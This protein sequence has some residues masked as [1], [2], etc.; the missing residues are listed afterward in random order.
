MSADHE[1]RKGSGGDQISVRPIWPKDVDRINLRC[2]PDDEEAR[3]RLFAQ[4]GT[5]GMAAWEGDRC[6]GQLHCYRVDLPDWESRD[7]PGRTADDLKMWPLGWPLL[8]AREARLTFGGSVWGHSCFH[9]GLT[10]GRSDADSSYHNRGIGT[11]MC[12]ASVDW[13][14]R[15]GYSAV[16]AMGGPAD[17][18]EYLDWMGV[19]PWTTYARMGFKTATLEQ[20]GKKLPWWAQGGASPKVVEQV[21]AALGHGRPIQDLCARSMVLD[22]T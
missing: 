13:A 14:R 7:F 3:E 10:L 15:H 12:M 17:L 22:M 6:V 2:W 1:D 20:D 21:K 4:Q 9:V 5:L 18:F 8:A 19:L 11:A 16:L